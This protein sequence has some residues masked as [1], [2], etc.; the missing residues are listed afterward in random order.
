MKA[1]E[2]YWEIIKG[3]NDFSTDRHYALEAWITA[4]EWVREMS[5]DNKL[6]GA[7]I[8]IWDEID[9]ELED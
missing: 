8:K 5:R 4:L 1:F 6:H 2:K 9:E 7:D 3:K